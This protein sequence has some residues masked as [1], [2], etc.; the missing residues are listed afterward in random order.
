MENFE[1]TG[2]EVLEN[3]KDTKNYN[4]TIVDLI[5]KSSHLTGGQRVLDFGAGVGTF[6]NLFKSRA[7][8]NVDC[9]EID[10]AQSQTLIAQGFQNF[11][12]MDD[13]QDD[14]YDLIYSLNVFE[15]IENDKEILHKLSSKLKRGATLFIFVPAWQY[16]YSD[17][18]KKV[19]HFRRYNKKRL[20]SLA[21]N[22]SLKV[23]DIFYFDIIG[24]ILALI[25]KVFNFSPMTVTT[26]KL[27]FFDK[28]LFPI[29]KLLDYMFRYILGKN[30][31][32]I[33]RRVD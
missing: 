12:N 7:L 25:F 32:M 13:V 21:E 33:C 6:A 31:I 10:K 9:F 19:G 26:K 27:V 3:L 24:Y 18:D 23:K 1:Y 11:Q 15:H 4:S 30:I 5:S 22:S 17:F 16:L 20:L 14:S 29:S 2:T 28:Y 8:G